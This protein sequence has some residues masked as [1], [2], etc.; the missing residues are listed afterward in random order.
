VIIDFSEFTASL[1]R[2]LYDGAGIKLDADP[3]DILEQGRLGEDLTRAI[4]RY[5]RRAALEESTVSR[6]EWL[7]WQA[8]GE[9]PILLPDEPG[10]LINREAF[11]KLDAKAQRE[12]IARFSV[13][14][15]EALDPR[16]QAELLVRRLEEMRYLSIRNFSYKPLEYTLETNRTFDRGS[17]R[18]FALLTSAHEKMVKVLEKAMYM[19]VQRRAGTVKE[20]DSRNVLGI[21]VADV[22]A[23]LAAQVYESAPGGPRDKAGR[24]RTMFDR[25]LLNDEW[26]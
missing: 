4:L 26:V 2:S 21:Q 7:F 3:L 12:L 5:S 16:R 11:D 9:A 19:Q 10:E 25:V 24:V 13:I 17:G 14:F 6:I 8:L 18:A 20:E 1:V 15:G 23:A 22:A